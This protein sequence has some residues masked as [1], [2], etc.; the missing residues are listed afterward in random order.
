MLCREIRDTQFSIVFY[1][2]YWLIWLKRQLIL[3]ISKT[4]VLFIFTKYLLLLYKAQAL[5][6]FCCE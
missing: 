6:S 5:A 3:L 4:C 1:L 2:G